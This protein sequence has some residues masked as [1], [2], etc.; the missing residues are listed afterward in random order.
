MEFK[1]FAG[2]SREISLIKVCRKIKATLFESIHKI[3]LF[4]CII[5]SHFWISWV[6]VFCW[7]IIPRYT[8]GFNDMIFSNSARVVT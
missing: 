4:L 1:C 2:M 8:F 7:A 6:G 3:L 5:L